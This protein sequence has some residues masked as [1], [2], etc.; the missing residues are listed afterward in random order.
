MH[1]G[2]EASQLDHGVL[3]QCAW[4]LIL[5]RRRSVT[6]IMRNPAIYAQAYRIATPRTS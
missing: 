2:R 4:R 6:W 3:G 1:K 5:S